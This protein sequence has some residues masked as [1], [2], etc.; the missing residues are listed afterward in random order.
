MSP[1]AWTASEFAELLAQSITILIGSPAGFAL[2]RV[3]GPEAELLTLAVHPAARRRG[4]GLTLMLAFETEAAARGAEEALLEVDA[5]NLAARALY[6]RMGYRAVGRR[7]GY[8]LRKAERPVDALVLH[9]PLG[10]P[11][12]VH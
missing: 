12:N 9:K 4:V 8:Y 5:S 11:P 10:H 2:G 6:A 7:P 1:R 3:A